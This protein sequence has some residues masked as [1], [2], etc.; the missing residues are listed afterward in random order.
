MYFSNDSTLA[1]WMRGFPDERLKLC[2]ASYML[3]FFLYCLLTSSQRVR[4][5]IAACTVGKQGHITF[6]M[7]R[8][9]YV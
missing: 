8:Y 5:D 6:S 3:R 9:L 7:C 1:G 4:N 2:C